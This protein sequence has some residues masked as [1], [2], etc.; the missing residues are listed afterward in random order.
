MFTCKGSSVYST[1]LCHDRRDFRGKEDS[2][3]KDD[4][5]YSVAFGPG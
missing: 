3:E 2:N 5:S 1:S 4:C